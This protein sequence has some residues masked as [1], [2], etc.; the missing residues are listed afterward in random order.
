M[1]EG[2]FAPSF[3]AGVPLLIG[4]AWAVGLNL[5]AYVVL[6]RALGADEP[7]AGTGAIPRM[8]I[9]STHD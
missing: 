7:T 4:L 3:N 1:L 5:A 8:G 6:R 9:D 2:A